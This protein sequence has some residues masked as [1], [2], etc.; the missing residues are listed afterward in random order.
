[1]KKIIIVTRNF[2]PLWGGMER[3]N[4][5][6]VEEISRRHEVCLLAPE[7]AAEHVSHIN[8][9]LVQV[10]GKPLSKFLLKSAWRALQ[11]ARAWKPDIILAGSGLTAPAALI[12]ARACGARAIAY[13][14]G[15][16]L[17]VSHPVYRAFWR[18]TLRRLDGVI[19]NS[20]ATAKLAE[21]IGIAP[22]RIAIVHPG[23]DLPV[24]DPDA[25]ARFR[26]AHQLGDGPLMLSVGRLTSRKGLRE[27]VSDVLP[28]IVT[29]FPGAQ[30]VVIGDAP[31]DSLYAHVQSPRSIEA[32]AKI[33]GV[34]NNLRFLGKRFGNELSDAYAGADLHVFPVRHLPDDP[35]GFGMVAVE[36]AA[37]GLATVAYATGG[38]V[39]AVGEGESGCLVP[40]GD[41]RAFADK[42]IALLEQGLPQ[43]R[44]RQFA[45]QFAWPLFGEKILA[46]FDS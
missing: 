30:L 9:R 13:T 39:D 33:H 20:Q 40:S 32:A 38:V 1:M 19:A 22:E 6:L 12:A 27:F 25:R 14:H 3:L 43:T 45:E 18:P 35:E 8:A 41:A 36:A 28:L 29:R 17:A 23:V 24:P 42:V 26:Q 2:P 37:H 21:T 7:G 4:L 15:L 10:P 46:T 34:E 31:S 16:D 44:V 5:H 11:K